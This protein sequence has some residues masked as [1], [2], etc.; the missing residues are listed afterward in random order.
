MN[1][2]L[3]RNEIRRMTRTHSLTGLLVFFAFFGAASPLLAF[4]LPD[5]MAAMEGVEGVQP[6]MSGLLPEATPVAA[7][8]SYV[9]NAQTL[10]VLFVLL[11]AAAGLALDGSPGRSTFYRV[12]VFGPTALVLPRFAVPAA[13]AVA[14]YTVGVLVA[15]AVTLLLIG[16]LPLGATLAGALFTG[17]FLV[18]AVAVTAL[19]ASRFRGL[20][21]TVG[22]SVVALVLLLLLGQLPVVG[23]WSPTTLV[24]AQAALPGGVPAADFLPAAVSALVGTA[25]LLALAVRGFGSRET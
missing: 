4:L 17:L 21:S 8:G 12:R 11:V 16:E 20:P 9:E 1:T 10:G 6:G 25:V 18:F 24:A 23:E 15:W 22:F 3:Y 7:I 5:L 13:A 19:V 14:S 2:A